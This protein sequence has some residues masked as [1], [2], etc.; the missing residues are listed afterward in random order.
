MGWISA[1]PQQRTG[2]HSDAGWNLAMAIDCGRATGD[3]ELAETATA[4]ARRLFL[5]DECAPCAYEPQADTF[6][7]S[8]PQRGRAQVCAR[9]IDECGGVA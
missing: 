6:T 5:A 9:C 3:A 1:S 2:V 8:V 4:A 7:S